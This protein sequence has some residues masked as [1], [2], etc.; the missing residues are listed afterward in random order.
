M[1]QK[2]KLG[3]RRVISKA[4]KK[5]LVCQSKKESAVSGR[6]LLCT[7]GSIGSINYILKI[8]KSFDA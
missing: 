7:V 3:N 6:I 8:S 5:V 4:R 1:A 2:L